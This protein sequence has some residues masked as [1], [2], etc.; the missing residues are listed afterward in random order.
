[1]KIRKVCILGGTGFVGRHVAYELSRRGILCRIP[2][3]RPHRARDIQLFPGCEVTQIGKFETE[4]LQE[5]FK[6]CDAVINLVGILNPSRNSS[7]HDIHAE[8]VSHVV[9]AAINSSVKH[10]L[11]MS[12]INASES[13]GKSNYLRL[14]G[15]GENRA[16]TLSR[17]HIAVTSFRPSVIFG[18]EDSFI[19]RFNRLMKLP[20]PL[21]L[22]CPDSKFAPVYVNDVAQAFA[23]A[24]GSEETFGKRYELCGPKVFSLHDIVDYIIKHTGRK[25]TVI[26]LGK[27]SSLLQATLLGLVP[28]KPFTLDNYRSLQTPAVCSRDGLAE[29]GV[30]ATS[31]DQVV[32]DYLR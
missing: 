24:L 28:G 20:G 10:L 19:N 27:N 7:Y 30:T 6:G 5:Q 18:A 32:P 21:P 8:L 15:E 17:H 2:S 13:C 29:L 12:A 4:E 9:D 31:M 22:A 1:M 16:H 23:N 26:A 25:K 3:R 11:H 14:K